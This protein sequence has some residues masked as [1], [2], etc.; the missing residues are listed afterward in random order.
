MHAHCRV[1]KSSIGSLALLAIM[2]PACEHSTSPS[3]P[4]SSVQ[5]VAAVVS[6]TSEKQDPLTRLPEP[7]TV[8]QDPIEVHR[9]ALI[10]A[11]WDVE[12]AGLVCDLLDAPSQAAK[13]SAL[14][15]HDLWSRL[16]R[17]GPI[18][19]SDPD[20][21]RF[22]HEHPEAALLLAQSNEQIDVLK[23]LDGEGYVPLF[24]IYT[25]LVDPDDR[26]LLTQALQRDGSRKRLVELESHGYRGMEGLFL[27]DL[28]Q[29][30]AD[31]YLDWLYQLVDDALGTADGDRATRYLLLAMSQK[32]S[33][34]GRCLANPSF[35]DELNEPLWRRLKEV[36]QAQPQSFQW[37]ILNPYIWDVL[38]LD[39]NKGVPI[40]N[41]WGPIGVDLLFGRFA[42]HKDVHRIV[43]DALTQPGRESMVAAL[44]S[45]RADHQN[46][47][48]SQ[49]DELFAGKVDDDLLPVAMGDL[50]RYPPEK[51][52]GRATYF[53]GLPRSAL[54]EDLRAMVGKEGANPIRFL[55]EVVANASG[56]PAAVWIVYEVGVVAKRKIEGRELRSEDYLRVAA[57]S[58]NYAVS[59]SNNSDSEKEQKSKSED[60]KAK[61]AKPNPAPPTETQVSLPGGA[62]VKVQ[63][64]AAK[65]WSFSDLLNKSLKD[66][67]ATIGR[68]FQHQVSFEITGP[69]RLSLFTTGS[70]QATYDAISKEGVRFS[71][72]GKFQS[73]AFVHLDERF[74]RD[75]L[76]K[77]LN[78][79]VSGLFAPHADPR[80][81]VPSPS[82]DHEEAWR[83]NVST[84]WYRNLASGSSH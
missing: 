14:D 15:D 45:L 46:V 79:T 78:G 71:V 63:G 40:L 61:D 38:A 23:V 70:A 50:L 60:P 35:A 33:I 83:R 51:R 49:I 31:P 73:M 47:H 20:L 75:A 18:G 7:Q 82:L 11:G 12:V 58:F 64:E 27:V 69:L 26:I 59:L 28:P 57:A 67:A 72:L 5:K 4:T 22:L 19:K 53:V 3:K 1:T 68:N 76:D 41:N 34:L 66:S 37:I 16:E 84:W 62:F 13:A 39:H 17:L 54:H 25:R 8:R 80:P 42:Y 43:T 24:S 52:E 29:S 56:A 48:R 32:T 10:A 81:S 65:G 30:V 77:Y 74:V 36:E 21:F 6:S 44:W 9:K 2:L 55:V